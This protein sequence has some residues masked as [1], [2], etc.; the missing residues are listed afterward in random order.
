[1]NDPTLDL[2]GLVRHGYRFAQSLTHDSTR[3]ED[4][5]QDAW[6]ALLKAKGPWT[7]AY[8]FTTIRNRFID[9]WRRDKLVKT[10]PLEDHPRD[11]CGE[12]TAPWSGDEH[13]VVE[14]GTLDHALGRLRP[15]ERAVLYLSAVEDCTAK[16]IAELLDLPRGTVLSM[17]HRG[18][19]KLRRWLKPE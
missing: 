2:D 11:E 18:R 17:I 15:E 14:N 19:Q 4:L 13:L 9:Q 8:L 10:E 5:V 6:F 1:M 3:A 12:A 16:Q 7:R